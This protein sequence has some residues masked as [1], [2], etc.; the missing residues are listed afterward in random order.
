MRYIF[1]LLDCT[2]YSKWKQITKW[3]LENMIY[4]PF[5][6]LY[7]HKRCPFCLCAEGGHPVWWFFWLPSCWNRRWGQ[8]MY[9]LTVLSELRHFPF[10][11]DAWI[12]CSTQAPEEL[13]LWQPAFFPAQG[14]PW[15]KSGERELTKFHSLLLTVFSGWFQ[16]RNH[17]SFL[18]KMINV[19]YWQVA[20]S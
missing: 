17:S 1:S 19:K 20:K 6:C 12:A 5:F 7:I 13:I 16:P 10:W 14:Q 15:R 4:R 9:S 2:V 8:E 11:T 3:Y 18:A